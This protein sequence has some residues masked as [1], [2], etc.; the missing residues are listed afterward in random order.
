MPILP[1][2]TRLYV[3]N[4][5]EK[6]GVS[7]LLNSRAT[8][9]TKNS[10]ILDTG[11]VIPGDVI[12]WA[13][14]FANTGACY[15]SDTF[16]EKGRIPVTSQLNHPQFKN[17]YAVG[18]IMLALDKNGQPYP[19]LGEAAHKEGAF[20]ATH[21]LSQL[22]GAKNTKSFSFKSAGT[23]LPLGNWQAIAQFGPFFISGPLAWW[24]R[25]TAYV[26]F[27]PGLARKFKIILDWTLHRWTHRYIID[28]GEDLN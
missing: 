27:L 7:I 4:N 18:D 16:C 20:V 8:S 22:M 26:L 24:I 28:L 12:I 3:K 6:K 19:Q 23:I 25:R 21:L 1:Q 14:G 10:V 9:V 2:K 5:L 15:L 13:A 11:K 17:L